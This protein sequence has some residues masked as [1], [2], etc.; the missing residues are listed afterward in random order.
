MNGIMGM[1][2]I[3]LEHAHDEEKTRACLEK[4]DVTSE[5][6]MALINDI[7]DMS[8]IESGKIDIKRETFDFA[9]FVGSLNAVFGTQALEQGI[10]HETEEAG[11]LPSLLVGDGLRLNQIIYNLVGNAFKFTP[12][13]GSVTLRIEELPARPD[14]DAGRGDGPIWLRFSVTDTGC[15]IE[16]ENRERIF[17]SFE[18]GDDA[19]RMRGG[20]GLGLAITK[21][22]A[23][24]MGGS[25]ALSSE[26]GKGSTFTVDIPFGR[27]AAGEGPEGRDGAFG[28]SRPLQADADDAYDFSGKQIV[29]AED[30][31]PQP[32]DRHRGARHDWGRGG[33]G[34]HGRRGR[35][36]VR[37][38]APGIR[39]P[40][41]HGH[42]DARDGRLRGD[43]R[44]PRA[45]PR[46]RAHGAH[47]RHDGQRVRRGRG[48]QP[49]E[50]NGW[51]SEQTP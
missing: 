8:K 46:R 37:A 29:I 10:R 11:A 38:V 28:L 12:C 42:P 6:L 25:I 32:R 19:S 7:L 14:E 26:V 17:S 5:H 49:H 22:F 18:Q 27:A 24:M 1:T 21:R 44:H 23:E 39:R 3:A 51:P 35:A 50:R 20:T 16:P 31:E 30:N 4:I 36:R 47:H 48:A 2:A 9:A 45:R 34:V 43:A 41:P 40:H 33:G 15:G 13:G